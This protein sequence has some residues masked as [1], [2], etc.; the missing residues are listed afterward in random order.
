MDS[1]QLLRRLRTLGHVDFVNNCL[2]D[3]FAWV[4]PTRSR[5]EYE[6]I[7][8]GFS[9]IFGNSPTDIAIVGSGKYG[10]SLSPDK[11]FR[12][13]QSDESGAYVS[14]IDLVA[15]SR[16]IFNETWRHLRRAHYN[17]A[18]NAR[19]YFQDDIFRRFIT[20]GTDDSNDTVYL[21]DLRM[22]LDRIRKTS[23]TKFGI[24]QTVK[25]RVYS[26]WSDAKSYHVWSLQK[27]GEQHGIQ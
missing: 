10:Y 2:F 8:S 19:R 23:T 27:L 25:L 24:T 1:N 9:E 22:L 7:R 18:V 15:I 4:C 26:S 20:V 11:D 17:G 12:P 16:P 21:R 5:A 3:D 13:F 14:D 6:D